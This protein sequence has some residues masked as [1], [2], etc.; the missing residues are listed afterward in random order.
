M[1]DA[2][3]YFGVEAVETE[4]PEGGLRGERVLLL[5]NYV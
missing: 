4:Y 1:L 5:N 2:L 3:L